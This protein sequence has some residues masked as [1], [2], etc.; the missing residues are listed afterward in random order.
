[1]RTLVW[2]VSFFLGFI[3][4]SYERDFSTPERSLSLMFPGAKV[5]VKN[6]VISKDQKRMI[7]K[8]ARSRLDS[9]LISVYLVKKG[10]QVIAYGYV[11]V[12]RV[13][14]HTE[15]VLFVI[16]PEGKIIAVEVLAFNEPLEYMAD[17]AWLDLFKGKSIDKDPL[18]L[19]RDIPNMTGATLTARGILKASRRAL[20]IWKVLFGGE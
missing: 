8:I 2:L 5:I 6:I 20:A 11:D 13:R 17:E 4:F 14:T 18:R 15:S 19:N 10:D 3:T 9:R 1:M 7:E 16:S 12:H